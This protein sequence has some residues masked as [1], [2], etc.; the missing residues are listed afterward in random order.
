VSETALSAVNIPIAV[1]EESGPTAGEIW[2]KLKTVN[3]NEHIKKKGKLSYLSWTWAYSVMMDNFPEFQYTVNEPVFHNDGS[4]MVFVVCSVGQVSREMWLPVMDNR[5][6]S[7]IQPTSRDI[8]DTI[9]RCLVKCIAMFGLGVYIYAGEDLPSDGEASKPKA[10]G[11]LTDSEKEK[12]NVIKLSFE[13]FLSEEK[14]IEDLR[15]FYKKNKDALEWMKGKS[16]E[17]FKAVRDSFMK[18]SA[19]LTNEKEEK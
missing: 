19:E 4:V 2:S 17:E 6:N 14:S 7:I 11:E 3:V 10:S 9:M 16:E 5:N 13:S 1:D 18:K 8:S 15:A 12:I